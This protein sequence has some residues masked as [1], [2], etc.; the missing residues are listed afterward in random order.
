MKSGLVLN[1][2]FPNQLSS[3]AI[4]LQPFQSRRSTHTQH[5]TV[6]YPCLN[7]LA[8]CLQAR[9]APSPPSNCRGPIFPPCMLNTQPRFINTTCEGASFGT[10]L[11]RACL[12]WLQNITVGMTTMISTVQSSPLPLSLISGSCCSSG[13]VDHPF[14]L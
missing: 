12:S 13:S 5:P 1:S 3:R 7:H 10:A 4:I 6:S 8:R 2:N 9:C 14:T 11:L